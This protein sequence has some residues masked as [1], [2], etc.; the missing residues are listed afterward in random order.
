[1][2]KSTSLIF[3]SNLLAVAII[4]LSSGQVLASEAY[5]SESVALDP[6]TRSYVLSNGGKEADFSEDEISREA[7]K[8]SLP[9]KEDPYLNQEVARR[10][11]TQ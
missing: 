4:T 6:I 9:Y 11:L 2:Q 3:K 10:E 7:S 1:M 8:E 5:Q